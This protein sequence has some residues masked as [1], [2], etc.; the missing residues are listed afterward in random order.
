M[1]SA[2]AVAQRVMKSPAENAARAIALPS[3]ES[4]RALT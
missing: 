2:S 4:R 3:V 1:T